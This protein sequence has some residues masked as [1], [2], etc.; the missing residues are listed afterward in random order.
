MK[1]DLRLCD[2]CPKC[3]QIAG[4]SRDPKGPLGFIWLYECQ[5]LGGSVIGAM[6]PDGVTELESGVEIPA[7]CEMR[8]EHIMLAEKNDE[9]VDPPE[10]EFS[11]PWEG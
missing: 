1:P 3:D 10:D 4:A 2:Q 7:D 6:Y 9:D 8:L 11:V 5:A